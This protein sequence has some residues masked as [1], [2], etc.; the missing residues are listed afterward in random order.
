MTNNACFDQYYQD[1]YDLLMSDSVEIYYLS[2]QVPAVR[3]C[4]PLSAGTGRRNQLHH[5]T[6]GDKKIKFKKH[7]LL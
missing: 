5:R 1:K 2:L 6:M 7:A 4:T 3:E